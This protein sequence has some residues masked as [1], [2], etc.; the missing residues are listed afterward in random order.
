M[1]LELAFRSSNEL[2]LSNAIIVLLTFLLIIK[3]HFKIVVGGL[4]KYLAWYSLVVLLCTVSLIW[5]K[6]NT[7]NYVYALI[8]DTYIPFVCY[9]SDNSSI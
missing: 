6:V 4:S 9:N 5:A 3:N 1:V 8:K 2:N 7:W